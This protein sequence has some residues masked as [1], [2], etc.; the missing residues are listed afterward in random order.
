[1][2]PRCAAISS[3]REKRASP[4]ARA[5]GAPA[6]GTRRALRRVRC[7]PSWDDDLDLLRGR[8][9]H[10]ELGARDALDEG[11]GGP[12]TLLEL[13]LAPFDFQVVAAR[14]QSLELDEH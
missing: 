13:Q 2:V 4:S 9:R 8:H 1:M 6:S 7:A 5:A 12:G 11:M 10:V 3:T 14:V